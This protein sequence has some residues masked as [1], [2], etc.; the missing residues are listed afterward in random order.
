MH[1]DLKEDGLK[2]AYRFRLRVLKDGEWKVH[3]S[4]YKRSSVIDAYEGEL[5]YAEFTCSGLVVEEFLDGQWVVSIDWLEKY[6]DN[7]RNN[8]TWEEKDV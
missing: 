6:M 3:H 2:Y 4:H 1:V 8:I 7:C 5:Q